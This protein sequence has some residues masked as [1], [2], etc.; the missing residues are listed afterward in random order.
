MRVREAATSGPK[1]GLVADSMGMGKTITMLANIVNGMPPLDYKET[2]ATL[3]IVPSS[4]IHQW[5]E[6]IRTHCDEAMIGQVIK[7]TKGGR[8]VQVMNPLQLL[9]NSTII[10]TT[11]SEII[12]SCPKIV[13]PKYLQSQEEKEDY[14][15]QN[16]EKH[17]GIFHTINWYRVVVDEAHCMKNHLSL[18][19]LALRELMAKYRWALT[20]TPIHNNTKELYPYFKFL[21]VNHT[22]NYK[23]FAH[24]YDAS[25]S[26]GKKRLLAQLNTIMLRRTY[27]DKMLNEPLVKLPQNN[28]V[29]H[30][31]ELNTIEKKV[32]DI[33]EMR[34]IEQINSGA[35][36][37][38]L[39]RNYTHY[40]IHLLRLRQ[41]A[42][43]IVLVEDCMKDLLTK[44][45]M[46]AIKAVASTEASQLQ[47]RGEYNTLLDL[48]RVLKW[49]EKK[50][51][52]NVE[53][54]SF[55]PD[56]EHYVESESFE[57]LTDDVGMAY[58][59]SFDFQQYLDRLR[60]GKQWEELRETMKCSNCTADPAREPFI[61]D[62]KHIYCKPCL[63]RMKLQASSTATGRA[64]CVTCG[65]IIEKAAIYR[66]QPR[67][68]R[69]RRTENDDHEASE[70]N[71]QK[72]GSKGKKKAHE[73]A[74]SLWMT[75]EELL[76]S[77][78]TVAVKAQVLNWMEQDPKV[79][80]IIF[81]QFV[82][83]IDILSRMCGTEGWPCIPVSHLP[84][85]H[86]EL[87]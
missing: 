76:P 63:H 16:R 40:F 84:D 23:I 78:K 86:F 22:G 5:F 46:Q 28:K 8:G 54:I 32:Y 64:N 67:R 58:G 77:T 12:K 75:D 14:L 59:L 66:E 11:Y 73:K 13:F 29:D 53:D 1:G 25:N 10:L 60:D 44:E 87:R 74:K 38:T 43:H 65:E 15:Y 61:T 85:M 24:N 31:L 33:L 21:Q 56:D 7:F 9:K 20:A 39:E 82:P 37:G 4:I 62:C 26:T 18:T 55:N 70:T 19:S 2:R 51:S 79:K 81:T 35:K 72:K 71:S 6:E 36:N 48:R 47:D 42:S 68:A 49:H 27:K 30:W 45:D 3:I 52:E 17:R 41:M 34:I 80:V 69:Q 50:E 57:I 83:M